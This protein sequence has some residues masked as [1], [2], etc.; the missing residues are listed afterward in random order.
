MSWVNEK[1]GLLTLKNVAS[2]WCFYVYIFYIFFK[3]KGFN[4][5]VIMPAYV[6]IDNIDIRW[7][8]S[9]MVLDIGKWAITHKTI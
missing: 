8:Q 4:R 1:N 3:K 6:Y 9:E 5:V 7:L 2:L